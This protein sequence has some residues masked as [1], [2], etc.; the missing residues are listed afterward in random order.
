[1][2]KLLAEFRVRLVGVVI[3][4]DKLGI[5]PI[6]LDA[7]EDAGLDVAKRLDLKPRSRD[8]LLRALRRYRNRCEIISVECSATSVARVAVRDRR[9]DLVYFQN[10]E[11]GNIFRGNLAGNCRAVLEVN[12]SELAHGPGFETALRS[13]R[14][15]IASA[16]QTS[17]EVTGSTNASSPFALRSPRDIAGLL[18]ILGLSIRS[19]LGAVSDIPH[20]IVARNRLRAKM[21]NAE[22]GVKVVRRAA[23]DE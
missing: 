8:E 17:V 15:D 23:A 12:L 2:A 9:V 5:H 19:A 3:P 1:M 11:R 7:F 14:R 16:A 10:R 20:E 6:V 13:L 21:P 18:H 4:A 22:E